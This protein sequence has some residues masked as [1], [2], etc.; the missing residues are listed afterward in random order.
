M[1]RRFHR[2]VEDFVCAM[3]GVEVH[4]DGYTNHCPDCL[5]SRHVD[6]TWPGDRQAACRGLM[7]PVAARPGDVGFTLI[8]RCRDCGLVRRNRT[9]RSDDRDLLIAL[10]VRAAPITSR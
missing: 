9:G 4:G 3:C 6:A 2:V 7:E 1:A 10:T 5:W 8:H